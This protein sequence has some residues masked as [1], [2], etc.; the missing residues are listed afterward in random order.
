MNLLFKSSLSLLLSSICQPQG[1][2]S[3]WRN[4]VR[5]VGVEFSLGF[6]MSNHFF[7]AYVAH[8]GL[9]KKNGF[10]VIRHS[11]GESK[12]PVSKHFIVCCL[13][14]RVLWET[15]L[16][17]DII[18]SSALAL[19]C[20]K[21]GSSVHLLSPCV[22]FCTYWVPKILIWLTKWGHFGS[23]SYCQR[24]A[25]GL[26]PCFNLELRIRFKLGSGFGG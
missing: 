1:S 2:K 6:G 5:E 25:W 13:R 20:L 19:S 4:S 26:R 16:N 9:F 15:R 22:C 8:T 3:S 17:H 24:T 7:L 12:G 23:S 10:P 18:I 14:F 21:S 11:C